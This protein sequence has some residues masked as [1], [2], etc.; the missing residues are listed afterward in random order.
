MRI[1]ALLRYSCLIVGVLAVLLLLIS[2]ITC[3]LSG[4]PISEAT[5]TIPTAPLDRFVAGWNA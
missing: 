4:F 2:L 3:R 5:E 1:S